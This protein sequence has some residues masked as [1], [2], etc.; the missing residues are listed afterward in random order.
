MATHEF[1]MMRRPPGDERYDTYDPE[2]YDCIAIDDDYIEPLIPEFDGILCYWHTRLTPGDNLAYCGVT[3]IP[4]VSAP[5]F[6]AIFKQQGQPQYKAIISLFEQAAKE[7]NY[8]IH[9]GL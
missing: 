4:P 6:A 2:K 1:G 3:L 5:R 9:Y 7:G 8:I